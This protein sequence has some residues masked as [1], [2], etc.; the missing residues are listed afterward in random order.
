[1]ARRLFGAPIKDASL[2]LG[3]CFTCLTFENDEDPLTYLLGL[4]FFP[5][6]DF[7][8]V[9]QFCFGSTRRNPRG[10]MLGS[11][12]SLSR[13]VGLRWCPMPGAVGALRGR[14]LEEL[15]CRAALH[16]TSSYLTSGNAASTAVSMCGGPTTSGPPWPGILLSPG[17][18]RPGWGVRSEKV[19]FRLS[20]MT[21]ANT[22]G[23]FAAAFVAREKAALRAVPR[24]PP[25]H[26]PRRGR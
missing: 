13:S 25:R 17:F 19:P 7:V 9:G 6:L 1:M 16:P 24:G 22:I 15:V 23:S 20:L 14:V 2:C 21:P 8:S 26:R 4:F 3:S 18:S 11:R 12:A 10:G 5:A